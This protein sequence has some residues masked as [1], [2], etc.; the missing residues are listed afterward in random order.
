MRPAAFS[1]ADGARRIVLA[2]DLAAMGAGGGEAQHSH[3]A[4]K[5]ETDNGGFLRRP[6]FPRMIIGFRGTMESKEGLE[7]A[8]HYAKLFK[9][10]LCGIFV[11]DPDLVAWSAAPI[12]RHF[13]R[14]SAAPSSISPEKLSQALLAAASIAQARL[15]HAA[16]ALG[17]TARFEVNRASA[18]VRPEGARARRASRLDRAGRSACPIELPICRI[19]AGNRRGL[20]VGALCSAWGGRPARPC[21]LQM[22]NQDKASQVGRAHP[23]NAGCRVGRFA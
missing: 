11:E 21:P 19:R 4:T 7:I 9:S 2:D 10:E 16:A 8:A 20:F 6:A 14:M 15:L 23:P 5:S 12:A 3:P 18:L 13:S 17:L 1:S 22:H